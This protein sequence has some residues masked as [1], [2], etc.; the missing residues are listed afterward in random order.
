MTSTTGDG[1]TRWE[2]LR[3]AV[4]G[5]LPGLDT[6]LHMGMLIFP[7]PSSCT[8]P[9]TPNVAITQP[10]ADAIRMALDAGGPSA[11]PPR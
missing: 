4:R 10:S 7:F 11:T 5:V 3:T 8:V 1:R 6:S 2:A 9:G